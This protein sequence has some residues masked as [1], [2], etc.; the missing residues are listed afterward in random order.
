MSRSFSFL[1][2]GWVA[3]ASVSLLAGCQDVRTTSA[4]G[5]RPVAILLESSSAVPDTIRERTDSVRIIVC[6]GRDTLLDSVHSYAG[7][8]LR[9]GSVGAPN[10]DSVEVEAIGYDRGVEVWIASAR[11][12]PSSGS[13]TAVLKMSEGKPTGK[14]AP[15]RGAVDMPRVHWHS[16]SAWLVDSTGLRWHDQPVRV[17]VTTTTPGVFLRYSLD[18]N[19]PTRVSPEYDPDSGILVDTTCR[20]QVAA[21][22]DGWTPSPVLV[23]EY[24][25]Q[26]RGVSSRTVDGVPWTFWRE[27]DRTVNYFDRPVLL[28]LA[29]TTPDPEIR[30]TLDGSNPD[31]SSLLYPD[32]GIRL[33]RTA[34]VRAV[35]FAGKAEPAP[36]RFQET[37]DFMARPVI[38]SRVSEAEWAKDL[39]DRP[40]TVT[41]ATSTPNA[42]I[43]Y[44]LDGSIPDTGSDVYP[45]SGLVLDAAATL[46]AS[47]FAGRIQ[48]YRD[49]LSGTF[50]FQARPPAFSAQ[51]SVLPPARIGL[52]SPTPDVS[53]H[54]TRD[55]SAPD[56]SDSVYTDSL[57]FEGL[58]DSLVLRAVAIAHRPGVEASEVAT[59]VVYAVAPWNQTVAYGALRD[60]RDGRDYRTLRLG[61]LEWMAENLAYAAPRS[62]CLNGEDRYCRA[63]GRLYPWSTAMG[64]GVEAEDSLVLAPPSPRGVCPEGWRL[65]AAEDWARLDSLVGNGRAFLATSHGGDAYGFRALPGGARYAD[66]TEDTSYTTGFWWSSTEEMAS[67]ASFYRL[68]RGDV[69]V[70]SYEKTFAISVRCIR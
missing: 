50:R 68:S 45:P 70:A 1:R 32:S 21:W 56:A 31:R 41:L 18:G 14:S 48:P 64:L 26:A 16:S 39:H 61:G 40:V 54:Y 36:V 66:G 8:S 10:G 65:P 37:F 9:F 2:L 4:D 60:T 47:A 52:A 42:V 51:G 43:R 6:S 29:T 3:V 58:D 57:V 24:R 7:E 59:N 15:V 55:G 11:L 25:F 27:G 5:S 23:R 34:E 69:F 35:V 12:P 67:M 30:Y 13:Q 38:V 19:A 62:W 49:A 28:K 22:R 33:D 46:R 63:F 17:F 20:L 53:I 44:T